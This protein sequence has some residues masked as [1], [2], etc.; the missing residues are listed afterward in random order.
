[1]LGKAYT[2]NAG[3]SLYRLIGRSVTNSFKRNVTVS[4]F[5]KILTTTGKMKIL[6][7]CN[8]YAIL[9]SCINS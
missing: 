3:K 5:T 2:A 9:H 1:M 6:K 8:S 7:H 4:L